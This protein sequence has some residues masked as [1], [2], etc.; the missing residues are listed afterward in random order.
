[1]T[2]TPAIGHPAPELSIDS[3]FQ[4]EPATL[5]DLIGEV[6]LI[7][8]FQVNCTGCFVHALPEVLTFHQRYAESGL[9]V[10]GL[11][12]AF[13]DFDIN[14]SG[15]LQ[16]LLDTGK[17]VGEPLKQLTKAGFLEDGHLPYSLPFRI[18]MD[19]LVKN[20]SSVTDEAVHTFI[21]QQVPDYHSPDFSE[22]RK[23]LLYQRA[24]DY[25]N[26]K[27]W[28]AQTFETYQLQGTPSS[29]L[30]DKQGLLQDVSFGQVNHLEP[31]LETLLSQQ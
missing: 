23:K 8:V 15:N 28:C 14:T 22:E 31:V 10:I 3:W 18:A 19:K 2:I 17:P 27:T 16:Y 9:C 12:T 13:E 11:A 26:S 6:V 4:G 20:T 21:Q 7:E 25:L 1:M 5:A 30:I 24:R 29:I